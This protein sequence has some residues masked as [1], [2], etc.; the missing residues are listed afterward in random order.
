MKTCFRII[1]V[2]A[3]IALTASSLLSQG[4]VNRTLTLNGSTSRLQTYNGTTG[5]N[6]NYIT[7]EA[8][9]YPT[10]VSGIN[11]IAEDAASGNSSQGWLLYIQDGKLVF[12]ASDDVC[13]A[14]NLTSAG[15]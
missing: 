1:T 7:V 12:R 5:Y 15:S 6:P 2:I 3:A 11:M 10:R 9:I 13:C 8:W 4:F 14:Q